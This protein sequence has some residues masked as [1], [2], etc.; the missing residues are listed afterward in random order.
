MLQSTPPWD[1]ERGLDVLIDVA[2]LANPDVR[3]VLVTPPPLLSNIELSARYAGL[4]AE[5]A[6]KH[7]AAL[8]DL[9]RFFTV[10]DTWRSY[11]GADAGGT[12]FY[13]FPNEQGQ[14]EVARFIAAKVF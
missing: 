7:K 2:R 10:R 9:H 14:V 5:V 13:R 6:D 11:Y 3:I 4:T 8:V 1:Y 12:L